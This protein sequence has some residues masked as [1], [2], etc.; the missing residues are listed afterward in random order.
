M[1]A[2][3]RSAV[4]KALTSRKFN[5]EFVQ[6]KQRT[7]MIIQR[8]DYIACSKCAYRLVG[9]TEKH[10]CVGKFGGIKVFE[11]TI[12]W[13]CLLCCHINSERVEIREIRDNNR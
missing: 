12:S 11:V 7:C 6:D 1:R 9:R 8:V 4:G 13:I 10:L 2:E 5:W 3:N